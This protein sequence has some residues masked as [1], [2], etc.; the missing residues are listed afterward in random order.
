LAE[1][2]LG[3]FFHFSLFSIA[4]LVRQQPDAAVAKESGS[5]GMVGAVIGGA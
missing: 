3:L 1:R 2:K 4:C 5:G